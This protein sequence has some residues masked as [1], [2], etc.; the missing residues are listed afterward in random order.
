MRPLIAVLILLAPLACLAQRPNETKKADSPNR[1]DRVTGSD[2]SW[3]HYKDQRQRAPDKRLP[4]TPPPP[5]P[6]QVTAPDRLP[7]TPPP[8]R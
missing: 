8:P 2:S 7:V 5:P 3:S 1:T 4:D 6:R